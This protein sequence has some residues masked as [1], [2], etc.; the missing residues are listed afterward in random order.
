MIG[1]TG[2]E[3][4]LT[5]DV[6]LV[7]AEIGDEAAGFAHQERAGGHIPGPSTGDEDGG[8]SSC[9]HVGTFDGGTT[10]L[11]AVESVK[12]LIGMIFYRPF[13]IGPSASVA[14]GIDPALFAVRADSQAA[15]IQVSALTDFGKI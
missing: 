6:P 14:E 13:Y 2:G 3:E 4:I 1:W 7:A 5:L 8:E 11:A 10:Q 15:S 12:F 9:C